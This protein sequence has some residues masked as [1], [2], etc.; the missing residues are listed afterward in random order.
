ME[1]FRNRVDFGIVLPI[2]DDRVF[3]GFDALL[4]G[5]VNRL[6]FSRGVGSSDT[7]SG[8]VLVLDFDIEAVVEGFSLIGNRTGDG[9]EVVG[10]LGFASAGEGGGAETNGS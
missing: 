1:F 10:R 4:T 8:T 7:R 5:G 6:E 2:N 9:D 3:P